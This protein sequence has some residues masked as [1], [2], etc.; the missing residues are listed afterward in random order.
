MKLPAGDE[1]R[2]NELSAKAREG[3]LLEAET[4]QSKAALK[5]RLIM[6]NLRQDSDGHAVAAK[7]KSQT[8]RICVGAIWWRL[9]PFKM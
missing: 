8:Y 1:D 6:M 2:V 4:H 9:Q 3:S 5:T 7:P